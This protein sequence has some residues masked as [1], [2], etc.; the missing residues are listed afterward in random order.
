VTVAG[1]HFSVARGIF[2]TYFP[3]VILT[4]LHLITVTI[5]PVLAGPPAPL[6]LKTM[7]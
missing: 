3:P 4:W 1:G 2:R 5:E 6:I 7:W